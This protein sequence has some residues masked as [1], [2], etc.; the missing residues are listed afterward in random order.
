MISHTRGVAKRIV[1]VEETC[2][3]FPLFLELHP[4]RTRSCGSCTMVHQHIFS[5]W[6]TITSMLHIPEGGLVKLDFLLD[7][8]AHRTSIPWISWNHLKSFACESPVSTVEDPTSLHPTSDLFERLQRSSVCWF[9]LCYDR[10]CRIFDQS[11]LVAFLTSSCDKLFVL[12]TNI[13]FEEHLRRDLVNGI[14]LGKEAAFCPIP[15]DSWRE[16]GFS[17]RSDFTSLQNRKTEDV[18]L[19]SK[20]CRWRVYHTSLFQT[21]QNRSSPLIRVQ[22]YRNY[23]GNPYLRS[24]VELEPLQQSRPLGRQSDRFQAT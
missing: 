15:V 21:L 22:L 8:C 1:R 6:C 20:F 24:S 10:C 18:R 7:L 14:P 23:T 19:L 12:K 3:N 2:A 5:L 16:R 13:T 17:G 4:L 9:R 11:L